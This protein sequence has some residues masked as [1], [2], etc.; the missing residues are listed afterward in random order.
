MRTHVGKLQGQCK[1]IYENMIRYE[2]SKGHCMNT[3]NSV[4]AMS[5]YENL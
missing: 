4:I 3:I 2:K 5:I 1:T